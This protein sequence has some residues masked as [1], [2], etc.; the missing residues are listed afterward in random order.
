MRL[1]KKASQ[2]R[3]IETREKAR[4]PRHR[5]KAPSVREARR[6]AAGHRR[7]TAGACAAHRHYLSSQIACHLCDFFQT[8]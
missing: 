3:K 4:G 1:V 8:I 2:W 7:A 5:P 6:G